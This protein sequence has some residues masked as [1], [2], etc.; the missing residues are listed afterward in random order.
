[1]RE[2]AGLRSRC[3]YSSN[4]AL[5]LDRLEQIYR[6]LGYFARWSEQLQERIF[7]LSL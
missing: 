5:P 1:M 7:Q 4:P 2:K 3:K 6:L